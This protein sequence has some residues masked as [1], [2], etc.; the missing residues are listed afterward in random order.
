MS[1]S[2]ARSTSALVFLTTR[3]ALRRC[4]RAGCVAWSLFAW[5][6]LVAGQSRADDFKWIGGEG[7]WDVDKNWK[8]ERVPTGADNV[9]IDNGGSPTISGRAGS[10]QALVGG[11][12]GG[13]VNVVGPDAEWVTGAASV[14]FAAAG[15]VVVS[16]AGKVYAGGTVLGLNELGFGELQVSG[17]GSLF[18]S[19]SLILG[20]SGTGKMLIEDGG[21]VQGGTSGS[22]LDVALGTERTGKGEA[23]IHGAG[24]LWEGG[25][26]SVGLAG[27]GTI[28]VE[29]GGA[30]RSGNVILGGSFVGG[31]TGYGGS[32]IVNVTG[33]N[34]AWTSSGSLTVGGEGGVDPGI[35]TLSISQGG[36][37]RSASGAVIGGYSTS[38]GAISVDGPGSHWSAGG[39]ATFV[40]YAGEGSLT[41]RR[42]A[43]ATI[44]SA[45]TML[46]RNSEGT[47]TVTVSGPGSLLSSTGPIHVG[48]DGTA[49]LTVEDGGKITAPFLTFGGQTL[50]RGGGNSI[51]LNGGGSP[52]SSGVIET[53]YLKEAN[54]PYGTGRVNFNGGILRATG[55]Q[56]NFIQSIGTQP[57]VMIQSRG[58][59]IDTNGFQ[60]GISRPFAGFGG[61]TKLGEGTLM[62]S[63][64]SRYTGATTVEQGTLQL[65][66]LPFASG[67]NRLPVQSALVVGNTSDTGSATVNLNGWNQEVAALSSLGSTMS[68]V[69]TNTATTPSTLTVNQA[70]DTTFGGQL[71]GNLSLT[72]LGGGTLTLAGE[73]TLSG[74]TSVSGGTL[75]V[76]GSIAGDVAVGPGGLLRGTGTFGSITVAEGGIFSPGNSPGLA[77]V[78]GDLTLSHGATYLV[79]LFG[80]T[81]GTQYDQTKILGSLTLDDPILALK[82]GFTPAPGDAFTLFSLG[83][84]G[85]LF[86][87]FDGLA[88]GSIFGVDSQSFRITY[89]GGTGNDVV[90]TFASGAAVPEPASWILLLSGLGLPVLRARRSRQRRPLRAG[91]GRAS[92]HKEKECMPPQINHNAAPA[93]GGFLASIALVLGLSVPAYAQTIAP[94]IE[95]QSGPLTPALVLGE[96]RRPV[97]QIRLLLDHDG[98]RGTLILDPNVP[99]FDEFGAH[100]GGLQTPNVRSK[101]GPLPAVELPCDIEFVKPGPEKSLLFRLTGAKITSPLRVATRGPIL[102]AG[103]ARL[104]V[105]GRDKRVNTVIDMTR[106]GLVVP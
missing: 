92:A 69:V 75:A 26:F 85:G 79:D 58:A 2:T 77:T 74:L 47:G 22:L 81:A 19:G 105:L 5:S 11:G 16:G 104:L 67:D 13:G 84:T 44:T 46:G 66:A 52:E 103:P 28:T 9:G 39:D 91:V 17:R 40:G 89:H 73:N 29:N 54:D 34:A 38:R 99:E 55:A 101:P 42:G 36:S 59:Y 61:L 31:G 78:L 56:A 43:Q 70:I 87:T 21:H 20:Q 51:N 62:L 53:G 4:A 76:N 10:S 80:T 30:V 60:V 100:R 27:E 1:T 88:E 64:A 45:S 96:S 14:G 24:S 15:K 68:R 94:N 41:V 7:S 37:F 71:N 12:T 90:L 8:P 102:D 32:G 97:H 48:G 23:T 6:L 35:G 106:Y 63:D 3:Q 82:L 57:D 86:G 18:S 65:G 33:R 98:K 72:K 93:H 25:H 50:N 49:R 83:E 95:L